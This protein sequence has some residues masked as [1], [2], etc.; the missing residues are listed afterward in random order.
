LITGVSVTG[1]TKSY[2]EQWYE[3][4]GDGTCIAFTTDGSL[5]KVHATFFYGVTFTTNSSNA[6]SYSIASAMRG[7]CRYKPINTTFT[8]VACTTSI[9]YDTEFTNTVN[10]VKYTYILFRINWNARQSFGQ[11]TGTKSV[12]VELPSVYLNIDRL[13]GTDNAIVIGDIH[14]V[15]VFSKA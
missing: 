5:K 9:V 15:F 13:T 12:G 2:G 6:F 3:S 7:L 1:G 11:G 4:P 8:S 14:G 10:S